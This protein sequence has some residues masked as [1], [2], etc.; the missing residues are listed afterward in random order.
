MLGF[1]AIIVI[2][3]VAAAMAMFAWGRVRVDI[4]ALGV[5][6]VLILFNLITTDQVLAGFANPATVTIAAMFIVSHGLVRTGIVEWLSRRIDRLAGKRETRLLLVIMLTAAFLSAFLINTAIV[7]IFIPVAMVLSQDRKIAASRVLIPLSFASQFGGVC[8]LIGTSTNL[9]VNSIA[10]SR[11]MEP[12]GFFEFLPLGLALTGAGIVYLLA[13]GHWLLPKRKSTEQVD[14]YRLADYLAEL[15]VMEKSS[16]LGVTWAKSEAADGKVQLTNVLREGKFVSRRNNTKLREGDILLLH[17]NVD[18]IMAMEG[19]YGLK[20]LKNEKVHDKELSTHELKLSEILVP[21]DSNL[22]G[23]S[24]KDTD[25]FTRHHLLILGIQ[26]RGRPIRERLSEIELQENDTLLLQGKA[27]DISHIMNSPNVVVTN[28]L[29]DLYLRRNRA[30]M[31]IG[32]L[33]VVVGLTTFNVLGIMET[34]IIGALAMV[35]TGCLT[36]EEAYKAI[37]WKV[38]FLLAG[39]LPLGYALESSGAAG[40]LAEDILAPLA[41][42]GPVAMLTV[43]Y[44][45]T[46]LLTM[47]MSNNAAAAILGPIAFTTALAMDI[48]PRPLLV[49]I[50]F[51]ASTSFATPI[52]YQTNTMVFSPG[53]YKFTDFTRIGLPLNIIFWGLSVLL[54][55]LIWPF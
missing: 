20:L 19:K 21:P 10:V 37:D 38:I 46:S 51:A 9:I 42:N 43:L 3:I 40:W 5:L 34:A 24:F 12:F 44:L 49:A 41:G 39:V 8:T 23:R 17:G 27:D 52:G 26:R 28:E 25:F 6:V 7:A 53:G 14:R 13:L 32:I 48:D 55:P 16:L 36:I 54:I 47:V 11:G 33:A 4:V 22:V 1:E 31:A 50:T 2:V 45:V 18:E 35:M 15:K 29:T 30:L